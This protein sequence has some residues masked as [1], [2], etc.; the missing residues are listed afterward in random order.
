MSLC[1]L[2]TPFECRC[3]IEYGVDGNKVV[4]HWYEMQ[5]VVGSIYKSEDCKNQWDDTECKL[6]IFFPGAN[7]GLFIQT[8]RHTENVT[9]EQLE[10]D[11]VR[12]GLDTAEHMIC[13]LDGRVANGQFIG[14]AQIEFIRQFDT[15]AAARY[16]QYRVD[17][18]A[19]KEEQER[20][21]SLARQAQEAE[22]EAKRQA[23]IAAEK[24]NYLG[25][26]DNM[27]ALRFGKVKA[28]LEKLVRFDGKVMSYREFIIQTVKDGWIPQKEE[29]VTSW[30]GSKWEPKQSKPRTEYRLCK[31]NLCYTVSKTE[32]D[33]AEFLVSKFDLQ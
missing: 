33:F 23:E 8:L 26:A 24:A 15:N 20:Q 4:H 9:V 1:N 5:H 27:T 19:R 6:F 21:E 12:T 7:F 17:Y 16:A 11:S 28:K 3:V 2:T 31:D 32:F 22:E 18:Y 30:Y 29:G 10:K 25:W 13:M 14:N